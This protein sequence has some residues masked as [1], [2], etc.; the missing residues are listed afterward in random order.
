MFKVADEQGMQL[1]IVSACK[2]RVPPGYQATTPKHCKKK[3]PESKNPPAKCVGVFFFFY[4]AG[5]PLVFCQCKRLLPSH[6]Y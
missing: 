3:K 2:N 6:R 1:S 4:S 5:F